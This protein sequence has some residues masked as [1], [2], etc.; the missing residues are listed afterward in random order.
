MTDETV[1]FIFACT[2]E[3]KKELDLFINQITRDAFTFKYFADI[4]LKQYVRI[5]GDLLT[6]IVKA[7]RQQDFK[8]VELIPYKAIG[9]MTE[10]N[11]DKKF[12][13][14]FF[15]YMDFKTHSHENILHL[16][17]AIPKDCHLIVLNI[18]C[19]HLVLKRLTKMRKVTIVNLYCIAN[20]RLLEDALRGN[21]RDDTHTTNQLVDNPKLIAAAEEI[22]QNL[23]N[24]NP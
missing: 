22:L 17:K 20:D 5:L 1:D 14:V 4:Y 24:R 3:Q 21:F 23:I 12:K 18:F 10:F 6:K 8:S 11:S 9:T 2:E 19:F 13:I 15:P 7:I 16:R